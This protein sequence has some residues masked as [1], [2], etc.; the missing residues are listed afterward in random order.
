MSDKPFGDMDPE[1]F[2]REGYRVVDWIARYFAEPERYPVMSRVRP[3]EVRG[4]LPA[5]APE[6]GEAF[7][8]ILQDFE[9]VIV[10]G[11]THWNHPGFFAYF[12]ISGSGPGVLAEMLSAALNAQGMLWRTSPS[13]TELEEVATSW[14]RDLMGLPAAFQGVIYDTASVSSLHALAAAREAAVPGVR[15]EGMTGR[16]ELPRYRVYCSEHAHSS[17]DKA[18]IL[19]GIGH[20]GLRKI[21]ADGD[22]RMRPDALEAAIAEDRRAGIVPLAVV[23]TVGTTSTTSVDPVEAIADI[24]AREGAWLHVDCAYAGVAAIVPEYRHILRGVDR[25]DSVVVNPHKWLFTPFDLSAFYT[26]RMDVLVGAFALTPEYLRTSE[27]GAVRNLMDTGVQ[28]GRRFRALK[29]WMILRYFG[30]EGIRERLGEHMRL[31]RLFAS[32]VDEHPDF[33]RLAPV[34]FSVVCFRSRPRGRGWTEDELEMRNQLLLDRLNAT[35]EVFLSHTKL[36]GRFVLR[37]A[38]GN[39][40]TEER[41]V[42]RAWELVQQ[43]A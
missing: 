23:A 6:R 9:R 29:L 17:I 21:P 35:G 15:R 22:F 18:T 31:A 14:L 4:A 25:A 30:A 43:L 34:P 13:V 19:I 27:A 16:S 38:V 7:D 42:R 11:I 37:L 40:R 8:A 36:D 5:A 20:D 24:C 3:G 10:P 1:T 28:L 2:R 32:W 39:L 41:H 33:E 12:A 26:R